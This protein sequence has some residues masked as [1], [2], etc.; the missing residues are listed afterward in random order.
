MAESHT[1]ALQSGIYVGKVMHQRLQPKQH[2]FMYRTFSLCVDLDELSMLNKLRLLSI[3]RFNLLA[4]Y[5]RDHGANSQGLRQHISDLLSKRGYKH[6]SAR[7]KLLCYPR[8]LGYVFNPL[9]V[10]FCYD[11][12]D[13]LQ[14]ILY[15]VTNTFKQRHTYLIPADNTSRLEHS[16][17]KQMYV[18]PFMPLDTRY[19]FTIQ[20]PAKAV[21]IGI[22]QYDQHQ[23]LLFKATFAGQHTSI[24]DTALFRLFI[25]HPLMTLKVMIGIHW[26]AFQLWRKKLQLQP[27]EKGHRNSISW[28]DK[29]GDF[30][31]ESL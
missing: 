21:S 18:S 7:I 26:E 19:S 29:N 30:H 17:N 22:R 8:I 27:R 13:Q 3:N 1:Q 31:N 28:Y 14:V 2:G 10:Y 9:S 5:E 24:T 12:D 11:K 6:A 4:F 23:Q 25:S 16:C 20:P 15:E